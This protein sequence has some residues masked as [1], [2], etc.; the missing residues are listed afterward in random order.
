MTEKYLVKENGIVICYYVDTENMIVKTAYEV[1]EYQLLD[2]KGWLV[3][4]A[5]PVDEKGR[6]V[7]K[8]GVEEVEEKEDV[9]VT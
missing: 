5:W 1:N 4:N 6:I 9:M 7:V 2:L 8:Q 3:S